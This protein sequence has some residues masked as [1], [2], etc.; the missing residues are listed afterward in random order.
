MKYI[1]LMLLMG[2]GTD[3]QRCKKNWGLFWSFFVFSYLGGAKIR[4][5]VGY[6]NY[7]YMNFDY[8]NP[9]TLLDMTTTI[10]LCILTYTRCYSVFNCIRHASWNL[11]T[12]RTYS[13]RS[14][15]VCPNT[16]RVDVNVDETA[17]TEN[18]WNHTNYL[19]KE[20]Q[21]SQPAGSCNW[22]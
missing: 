10:S 5:F 11:F 8:K 2:K 21:L 17:I 13:G 6:T 4:F 16:R 19:Q 14:G 3:L 18:W 22:T 15:R 20:V 12:I 1:W 9:Q 7:L